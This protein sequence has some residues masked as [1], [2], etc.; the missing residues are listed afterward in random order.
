[1]SG[2]HDETEQLF[3][4]A[5]D[6]AETHLENALKES[7]EL[8]PYVAV[9]MIEAAVNQAVDMTSAEDVVS[10]LRDLTAQIE[11]DG[12]FDDDDDDDDDDEDD[13]N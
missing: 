8:A 12:D 6:V 3:D 9:A 7:G 10:M 13:E 4:K 2:T 5:L 1:M 11:A